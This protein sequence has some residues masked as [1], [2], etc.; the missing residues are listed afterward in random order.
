M[1]S[2]SSRGSVVERCSELK[3]CETRVGALGTRRFVGDKVLD[4]GKHLVGHDV[5]IFHIQKAALLIRKLY[6]NGLA[7]AVGVI[8]GFAAAPLSGDRLSRGRGMHTPT[9]SWK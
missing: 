6:N 8:E 9:T 3:I 4:R 5:Q 2:R 1:V 7:A